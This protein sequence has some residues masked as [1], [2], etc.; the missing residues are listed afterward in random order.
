MP[1]KTCVNRLKREMKEFL[2]EPPPQI[3][4]L[5]VNETNILGK[6]SFLLLGLAGVELLLVPDCLGGFRIAVCCLRASML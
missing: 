2:S 6:L 5:Y 1:S 3:P 4:E